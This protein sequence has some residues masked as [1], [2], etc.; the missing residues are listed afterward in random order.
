MDPLACNFDAS[1]LQSDGSCLYADEV[2][3]VAYLDCAGNC[4]EDNDGDGVCNPLEVP[5]CM[6]DEACNFDAMATDQLVPCLYPLPHRN[7]QGACL[8]DSDGDGVCDGEEILGCTLDT[9]C[10][11]DPNATDYSASCEFPSDVCGEPFYDCNCVCLQDS[12]ADGV[13]DEAEWPGC[14]DESACNYQ[15]QATENDGSCLY[16]LQYC[17]FDYLDCNCE[18]LADSDGDGICDPAEIIGCTHPIACN[19]NPQSREWPLRLQ[20]LRRLHIPFRLQL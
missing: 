9:A 10:N 14:D 15:S 20:Q 12:D 18:C 16:P 7:C 5:G 11:Y 2:W 1:A 17:G 6:D 19:F 8:L 3:G 13:C 4:L